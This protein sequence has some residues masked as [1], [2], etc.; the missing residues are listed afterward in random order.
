MAAIRSLSGIACCA[1][2]HLGMTSR[3]IWMSP[4]PVAAFSNLLRGPAT[5]SRNITSDPDHGPGKWNDEHIRSAITMGV[6]PDGT[7]LT[8]PMPFDW[9][10]KMT[11]G[12]LDAIVAYVRTIKPVKNE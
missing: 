4:L 11:P 8:G 5:V 1:I 12:D 9:Y 10:A 7:K 3:S 6:R 2:L